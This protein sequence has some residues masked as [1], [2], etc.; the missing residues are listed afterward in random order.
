MSSTEKKPR[1][2]S[3]NP[4]LSDQELIKRF[5]EAYISQSSIN[6]EGL[7]RLEHEPFSY[8]VID[9]FILDKNFDQYCN[10]LTNELKNIKMNQKNNDLYKFQQVQMIFFIEIL[11]SCYLD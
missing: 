2:V 6:E 4:I 7:L 5:R 11:S 8:C 1:L 3:V 9:D 10:Q